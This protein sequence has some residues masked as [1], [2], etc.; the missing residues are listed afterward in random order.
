MPITELDFKWYFNLFPHKTEEEYSE[1]FV[2]QIDFLMARDYRQM[3]G[4][5]LRI[6]QWQDLIVNLYF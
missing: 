3:R 1:V 4:E 5:I 6:N 2:F